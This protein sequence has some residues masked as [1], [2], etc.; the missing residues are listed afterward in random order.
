M[1]SCVFRTSLNPTGKTSHVIKKKGKAFHSSEM[2]KVIQ[3]NPA[4]SNSVNSEL[5]PISLE[6]FSHSFTIG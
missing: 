6:E 3:K 4:K 1:T 5:K 2:F